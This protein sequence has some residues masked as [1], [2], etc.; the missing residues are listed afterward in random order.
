[1]AKFETVKRATIG[2]LV[3]SDVTGFDEWIVGRITASD[4]KKGTISYQ[5]ADGSEEITIKRYNAYKAT[6]AEHDMQKAQ[7]DLTIS[8]AKLDEVLNTAANVAL[9]RSTGKATERTTE[10][11]EYSEAI[12]AAEEPVE[13]EED[14]KEEPL[15]RIKKYVKNYET[16]LASSGKKSKD[17]GDRVA[18]ELRGLTLDA[19]YGL[20]AGALYMQTDEL[21]TKYCHLNEGQQRMCLGNR[22]RGLYRRLEAAEEEAAQEGE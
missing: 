13:G 11:V 15:S 4:T 9:G 18:V 1:M 7:P 19:V 16:V 8:K 10:A 12:L 22:L 20:V 21:I 17:S 3:K 2:N 6:Q 5:P 14:G